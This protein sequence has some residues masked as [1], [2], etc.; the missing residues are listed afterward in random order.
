MWSTEATNLQNTSIDICSLHLKIR[1]D[2][3]QVHGWY[4]VV[5]LELQLLLLVEQVALGGVL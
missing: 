2:A 4:L 3:W 5:G 1:T